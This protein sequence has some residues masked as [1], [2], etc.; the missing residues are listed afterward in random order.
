MKS[1]KK[2]FFLMVVLASATKT[3][4]LVAM[5]EPFVNNNPFDFGTTHRVL[6]KVAYEGNIELVL[7]CLEGPADIVWELITQPVQLTCDDENFD[8]NEHGLTALHWAVRGNCSEVVSY[9]I[10][11]A[12][13]NNKLPG[14]LYTVDASGRTALHLAAIHDRPEIAKFLIDVAERYGDQ[15][16]FISKQTREFGRTAKYFAKQGRCKAIVEMIESIEERYGK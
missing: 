10:G 15:L 9:L 3:S 7:D 11:W 6:H 12:H 14:L 8:L 1:L 4:Q 2:V 5:V 13:T 16:V